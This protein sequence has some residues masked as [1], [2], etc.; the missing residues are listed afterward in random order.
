MYLID[1]TFPQSCYLIGI[2]QEIKKYT[3]DMEINEALSKSLNNSTLFDQGRRWFCFNSAKR[4]K[5]GVKGAV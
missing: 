4:Q 5:F 2:N 1:N 3:D